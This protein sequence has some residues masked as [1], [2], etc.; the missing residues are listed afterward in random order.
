MVEIIEEQTVT[1]IMN[2][3]VEWFKSM[4]GVWCDGTSDDSEVA[5]TLP[6]H[7]TLIYCEV[8]ETPGCGSENVTDVD[9]IDDFYA[10]LL[11]QL[12]VISMM[13]IVK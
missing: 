6:L 9:S 13:K 11:Y 10:A 1:T 4:I 2:D 12:E 8:D 3:L 5:F 7:E